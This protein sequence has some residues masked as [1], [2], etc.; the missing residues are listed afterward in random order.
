MKIENY[1]DLLE[2]VRGFC[3]ARIILSAQELG[4]YDALEKG[5]DAKETELQQV[6]NGAKGCGAD[7]VAQRLSLNPRACSL[8]LN[9]LVAIG[10]VVKRDGR[11]ENSPLARER[12]VSSNPHYG[13]RG[14]MHMAQLWDSWSHL[15]N[16]LRYGDEGRLER[17]RSEEQYHHFVG[18]MYDYGYQRAKELAESLDLQDLSFFLDLGGGPASYS[19]A[20]CE[21]NPHLR[22][23]LFDKAPAIDIAREKVKAHDLEA[24]IQLCVGD[25]DYDSIGSQWELI[26]ASHI[27]HSRSEEEN[28]RLLREI[29]QA[30]IPGGRLLLQDFYTNADFTEPPNAALFAI[31]MLV[32]TQD[33]RTYSFD[34]LANWLEDCGFASH[35]I[36]PSPPGADLIEAIK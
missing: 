25:F 33:G 4:I 21:K 30:L 35:R 24:R 32:N 16:I 12:L 28:R 14:I 1:G 9:A 2:T 19:I 7:E 20:L 17:S 11:Y 27:I 6:S 26:F 8:L 31:N 10:L 5:R 23:R 18:A 15:S 13:G 22:A 36:L 29:H 3:P 34:E